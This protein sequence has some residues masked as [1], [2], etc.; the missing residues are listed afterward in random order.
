VR[1]PDL[2]K[3]CVHYESSVARVTI[4]D[5]LA[6]GEALTV[7]SVAR[8]VC[9]GPLRASVSSNRAMEQLPT[10]TTR[11]TDEYRKP[12]RSAHRVYQRCTI[13]L[14]SEMSRLIEGTCSTD[15][16]H[17]LSVLCATLSVCIVVQRYRNS[18]C[19]PKTASRGTEPSRS[20]HAAD[21]IPSTQQLVKSDEP[22]PWQ[23]AA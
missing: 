5:S 12:P 7:W 15:L 4:Y 3:N 17:N 19:N 11:P 2:V 8:R 18:S 6:Y 14:F 13:L 16:N 1:T 10:W 22:P 9:S 21:T 23:A 20:R